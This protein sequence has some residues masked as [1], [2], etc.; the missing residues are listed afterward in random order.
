[1]NGTR[2][3]QDMW[4]PTLSSGVPF[5]KRV[6][7]GEYGLRDKHNIIFTLVTIKMKDIFNPLR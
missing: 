3:G 6:T 4:I 1:M 2:R 5:S 7:L